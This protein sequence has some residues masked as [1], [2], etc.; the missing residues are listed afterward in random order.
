MMANVY[1][2]HLVGDNCTILKWYDDRMFIF[3][4]LLAK[5][6]CFPFAC[7]PCQEA[8]ISKNSKWQVIV[9]KVSINWLIDGGLACPL[10]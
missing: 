8:S 9:L 3:C 1:Y 5:A 10:R 7:F 2:T 6:V 4:S